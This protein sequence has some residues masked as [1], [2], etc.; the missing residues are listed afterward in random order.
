MQQ[1]AQGTTDKTTIEED[2]EALRP[3]AHLKAAVV[4]AWA[5]PELRP[6][7]FLHLLDQLLDL[8][9]PGRQGA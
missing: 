7:S 2:G 3:T 5:L 4:E 8:R 9:R 1:E 6:S